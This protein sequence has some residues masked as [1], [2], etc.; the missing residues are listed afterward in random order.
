[1]FVRTGIIILLFVALVPTTG[2]TEDT[3][4]LP[5][6]Y[7]GWEVKD[8]AIKKPLCGLSGDAQRGKK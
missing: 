3:A 2:M 4:A 5:E 7:C 6:N 1:M 8:Y